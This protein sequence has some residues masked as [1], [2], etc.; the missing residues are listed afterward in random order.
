MAGIHD[1]HLV[2]AKPLNLRHQVGLEH[3]LL[4][5]VDLVRQVTS[6]EHVGHTH[7]DHP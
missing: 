1:L 3:L 6:W 4:A 7:P 2:R 5:F